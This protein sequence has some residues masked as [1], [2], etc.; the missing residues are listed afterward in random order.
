MVDVTKEMKKETASTLAQLQTYWRLLGIDL[1]E[2][3]KVRN[4]LESCVE[5]KCNALLRDATKRERETRQEISRFN[6]LNES[7]QRALGKVKS[8]RSES[9]PLSSSSSTA[10]MTTGNKKGPE[11]RLSL[12]KQRDLAHQTYMEIEPIFIKAK[13]RHAKILENAKALLGSLERGKDSISQTLRDFLAAQVDDAGLFAEN[14]LTSCEDELRKMR[15]MKSEL[16][17]KSNS[18][19]ERAHRLV[20]ETHT[21]SEELLELA[22]A[23]ILKKRGTLGVD[24]WTE[25]VC[26]QVCDFITMS[27]MK[28]PTSSLWG[29]H[30]EV[31]TESVE[32]IADGREEFSGKLKLVVEEAHKQLMSVIEGDDDATEAYTSFHSALF[33]LP[34]LSNEHI[35]ACVNEI[36]ILVGAADVMMQSE[37]EALTVVWDAL[38]LNEEMRGCF[39]GEC[40]E[41]VSVYQNEGGE[42]AFDGISLAGTDNDRDANAEAWLIDFFKDAKIFERELSA[43]LYRLQVIHAEVEKKRSKQD[44]KSIIMS[45]DSEIRVIDA[46]LAQF[47]VKASNKQRLVSKKTNS[48]VLLKEEK[49]RKHMQAKF[50]SKLDRLRTSLKVW[51][52]R[53]GAQFDLGL[54]SEEVRRLLGTGHGGSE[55]RTSFMH[56]RTVKST[57][58]IGAGVSKRRATILLGASKNE[59]MRG[60]KEIAGETAE[61]KRSNSDGDLKTKATNEGAVRKERKQPVSRASVAAAIAAAS[62]GVEALAIATSKPI[63]KK[64]TRAAS[65]AAYKL[66]K[67]E[68]QLRQGEEAVLKDSNKGAKSVGEQGKKRQ[69]RKS[70][71]GKSSVNPF[72][73]VLTPNKENSFL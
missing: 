22:R 71:R 66:K 20:S 65:L 7:M 68:R 48:G 46:K 51:E 6:D 12:L 54:V 56:L 50:I 61:L 11:H 55:D 43:K 16:L 32:A 19:Y 58:G 26:K 23:S 28:V 67:K 29:K 60:N 73:N 17:I 18:A 59:T 49:F 30:M 25:D 14:L 8:V 3:A 5:E 15:V 21:S 13:A 27:N 35:K 24:W 57:A 36:K 42:G 41:A 37:T 69:T 52:A 34:R 2:R 10:P 47:E 1:E 53:E 40:A 70:T 64:K 33:R 62:A 45:L 63:S 44:A 72:G 9:R 38:G 4:E 31:I 39:W